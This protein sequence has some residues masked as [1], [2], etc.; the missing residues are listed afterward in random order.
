LKPLAKRIEDEYE[1]EDEPKDEL[2]PSATRTPYSAHQFFP[3]RNRKTRTS[4][5]ATIQTI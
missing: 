2:S 1:Y 3:I 5:P 4:Y